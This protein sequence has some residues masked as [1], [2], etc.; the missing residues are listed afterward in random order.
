MSISGAQPS[1]CTPG[2]FETRFSDRLKGRQ[3]KDTEPELLLRKALHA[4]GARYRLQRRVAPRISADLVFPGAAVAVFVDGCFWHG[5]PTHG[6]RKFTGANA[7][8]WTV[9]IKR[10]QERDARATRQAEEEG[11]RVL[12]FWE[13]Q[14]KEDPL[15]VARLVLSYVHGDESSP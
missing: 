7:E 2:W 9:K 13:C 12:R 5:C 1:P 14:V 8:N 3:R 15:H 11:W 10:N 6:R 4:L